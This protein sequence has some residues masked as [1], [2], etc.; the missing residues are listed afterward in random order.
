MGRLYCCKEACC[1]ILSLLNNESKSY[2]S[3][4][5]KSSFPRLLCLLWVCHGHHLTA[6]RARPGQT[7]AALNTQRRAACCM[8]ISRIPMQPIQSHTPAVSSSRPPQ[9]FLSCTRCHATSTV[10]AQ[11]SA[12]HPLSSR[13][14]PPL[15]GLRALGTR[16]P[17][18][19]T[20]GTR[21]TRDL[22][23]PWATRLIHSRCLLPALWLT[24]SQC[25]SRWLWQRSE[26]STS[27]RQEG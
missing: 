12:S 1:D 15:W 11:P 9:L 3:V 25:R 2:F 23:S 20:R 24:A 4:S 17:T 8:N 19:I 6:G 13:T 16:L 18:P 10:T 14:L 27:K 26:G 21:T 22:A 5:Q 7:R